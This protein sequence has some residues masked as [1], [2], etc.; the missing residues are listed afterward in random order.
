MVSVFLS[1]DAATCS[2]TGEFCVSSKREPAMS[3]LEK[4]SDGWT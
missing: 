2:A 4:D 3:E 1:S